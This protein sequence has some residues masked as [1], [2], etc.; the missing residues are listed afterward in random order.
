MITAS[1]SMETPLYF[2][3]KKIDNTYLKLNY[4]LYIKELLSISSGSMENMLKLFS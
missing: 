2:C 3:V 4:E 1:A